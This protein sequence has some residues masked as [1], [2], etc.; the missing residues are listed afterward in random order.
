MSVGASVYFCDKNA[1][2]GKINRIHKM[3]S[4]ELNLIGTLGG[5]AAYNLFSLMKFLF[6]LIKLK[7]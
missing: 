3:G 7:Y 5:Q 2:K 6:S 4:P 1:L